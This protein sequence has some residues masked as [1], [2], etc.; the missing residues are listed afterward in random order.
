MSRAREI[1]VDKDMI[2]ILEF[3]R[4]DVVTHYDSA[5]SQ[6]SLIELVGKIKIK[7]KT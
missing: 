3:F 7:V 1:L 2:G 5:E 6:D 4:N